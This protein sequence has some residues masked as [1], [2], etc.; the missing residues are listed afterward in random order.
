M[1]PSFYEINHDLPKRINPINMTGN[2]MD[3]KIVLWMMCL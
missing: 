2:D 1:H 3:F